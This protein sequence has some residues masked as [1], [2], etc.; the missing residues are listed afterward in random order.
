M[1]DNVYRVTEIVGTSTE[2]VDDAIRK[3]IARANESLREL[4]WFE[5]VETR[6]HIENGAVAHFQVTLKVGFKLEA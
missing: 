1:S 2:G 4:D 5:V 6:G 3:A